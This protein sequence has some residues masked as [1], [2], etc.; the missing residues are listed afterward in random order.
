[1]AIPM[2]IPIAPRRPQSYHIDCSMYNAQ[3]DSSFAALIHSNAV[4]ALLSMGVGVDCMAS[5][6]RR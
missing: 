6:R 1:M 5:L 3:F 4:L 2:A